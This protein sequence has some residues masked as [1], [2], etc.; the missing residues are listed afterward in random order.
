MCVHACVCQGMFGDSFLTRG[1][2]NQPCTY[3]L[4]VF[5]TV[6]NL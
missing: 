4:S 2:D 6:T 1:S 5:S 3:D